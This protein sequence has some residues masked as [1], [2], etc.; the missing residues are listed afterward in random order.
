V[1]SGASGLERLRGARVAIWGAGTEG[2]AVAHEALARGARVRFVVDREPGDATRSD[3]SLDGE[4]IRI[5]PPGVLGDGRQDLVVRS[6]G[7]SV[8]RKEL[9]A[10]RKAGSTVTSATEMWLEDFRDDQVIAVTG[11][12]GKT[13]TAWLTALLLRATGLEVSLGGNMG[14]P[15][16]DLY[17]KNSDAY[18]IEVSSFQAAD[19]SVSPKVGVL[20]LLAPDHLDWHQGYSN[21]VRDKL[22]LFAHR[23]D[24]SLA[25]NASSAEAAEHTRPWGQRVLYGPGG[26]VTTDG[27][28]VMVDGRTVVDVREARL[29]SLRGMHNFVNVC[30]ALTACLL[31]RAETPD[32]ESIVAAIAQ[33]PV[34]PSRL[35]TIAVHDGVEFVNDALASNPA[36]AVAALRTFNGRRVCLIAGGQDRG[37]DFSP[38]VDEVSKMEPPPAI[39]TL[40]DAGVRFAR[41]LAGAGFEADR[42]DV[43]CVEDAVGAA[44]SL[45]AST[46]RV[47][48]SAPTDDPTGSDGT[49][50]PAVVL[51]SPAAPTPLVEGSYVQ[52]G[53]SFDA[54]VA[55]VI[56]ASGQ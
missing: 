51:F 23:D 19:V 6:P 56:G 1:S 16:T 27:E 39:V 32:P 29:P 52:R 45:L 4:S 18:V 49:E 22:N 55:K 38:L 34:L 30:G 11:T 20:T 12:K 42:A 7:V 9:Q 10:A 24:I 37:V 3:V 43:S 26:T 35:Q 44:L 47:G 13:T 28:R 36:G 46:R 21:Y 50:L 40:P 48:R 33:M 54:A 31:T 14:T 17:S 8:Y 15:L 5:E 41:E 53:A 2:I 25:V